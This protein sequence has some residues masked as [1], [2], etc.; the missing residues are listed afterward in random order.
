MRV[1]EARDLLER[2]ADDLTY[3][4]VLVDRAPAGRG[5]EQWTTFVATVRNAVSALGV[6]YPL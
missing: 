4:G 3:A 5:E 6:S 2:V 1:S